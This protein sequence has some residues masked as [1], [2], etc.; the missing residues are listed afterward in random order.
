ML[1]KS[2]KK[3]ILDVVEESLKKNNEVVFKEMIELFNTTNERID[4]VIEQLDGT[5]KRIDGTN[6]RIDKVLNV[7]TVHDKR[8]T[9]VEESVFTTTT[10]S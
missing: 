5:N 6:E 10:S 4:G 7:L 2:D 3:F 1:I 9:A 8:I